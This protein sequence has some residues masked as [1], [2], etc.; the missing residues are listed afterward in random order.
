MNIITIISIST[1]FALNLFHYR[2][3]IRMAL[4]ANFKDIIEMSE[5]EVGHVSAGF[6]MLLLTAIGVGITLYAATHDNSTTC[7]AG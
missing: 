3:E 5:E 7:Y 4:D 6:A 1:V 2:K